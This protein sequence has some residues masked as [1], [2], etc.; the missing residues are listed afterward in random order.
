MK[1]YKVNIK[2]II[3]AELEFDA[4]SR[5][6]AFCMLSDADLNI[7]NY[8]P[9]QAEGRIN[10]TMCNDFDLIITHQYLATLGIENIED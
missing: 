10:G 5:K 4:A 1:K 7:Q 2:I 9:C 6:D 3:D 8:T